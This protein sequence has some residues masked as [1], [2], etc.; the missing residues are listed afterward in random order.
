MYANK[1]ET[2]AFKGEILKVL[3]MRYKINR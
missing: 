1:S 3:K 2:G